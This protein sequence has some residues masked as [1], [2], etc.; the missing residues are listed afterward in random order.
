MEADSG[1]EL[2]VGTLVAVVA[3]GDAPDVVPA[4]CG[5]ELVVVDG[6]EERTAAVVLRVSHM[7]ITPSSLPAA[8]AVPSG[9]KAKACTAPAGS[10]RRVRKTIREVSLIS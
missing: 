7:R 2:V 9:L 1:A 8:S 3:M 10:V 6:T 5:K 4:G